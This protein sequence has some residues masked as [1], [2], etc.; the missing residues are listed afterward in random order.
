MRIRFTQSVILWAVGVGW[1]SAVPLVARVERQIVGQV[2]SSSGAFLEGVPIPNQ[3]TILDSDLL[4]TGRGGSAPL[5]IFVT[6]PAD[7]FQGTSL[8]V[9]PISSQTGIPTTPGPVS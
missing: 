8:P 6:P 5:K 3:G 4:T 9:R 1:L 7:N 2:V